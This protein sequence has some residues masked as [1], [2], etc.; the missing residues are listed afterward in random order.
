MAYFK[1]DVL[2]VNSDFSLLPLRRSMQEWEQF[3]KITLEGLYFVKKKN[4]ANYSEAGK[5][6]EEKNTLTLNPMGVGLA[7]I[8]QWPHKMVVCW[9]LIWD[10]DNEYQNST[11]EH[12]F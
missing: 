1:S 7:T 9:F 10:C 5:A 8:Y 3:T 6:P 11:A 2:Q 4:E 12:N